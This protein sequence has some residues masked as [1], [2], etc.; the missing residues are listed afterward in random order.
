MGRGAPV[1]YLMTRENHEVAGGAG[2][3]FRSKEELT[4]LMRRVLAMTG[5]EREA[6]GRA[7]QQRVAE[8]YGWDRVTDAYESLLQRLSRKQ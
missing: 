1:L 6:M 7:A 4:A 2:L 8:R 5:A 3:P